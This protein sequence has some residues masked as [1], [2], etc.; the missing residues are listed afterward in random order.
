MAATAKTEISSLC[1]VLHT[2]TELCKR[3]Q[4]RVLSVYAHSPSES[5]QDEVCAGILNLKMAPM[6]GY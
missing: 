6:V 2:R 4:T 1:S 5:S 3:F